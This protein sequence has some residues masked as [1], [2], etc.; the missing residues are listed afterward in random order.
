MHVFLLK[1]SVQLGNSRYSSWIRPKNWTVRVLKA[2]IQDRRGQG[3]SHA[4]DM[5]VEES[6]GMVKETLGHSAITIGELNMILTH[7]CCRTKEYRRLGTKVGECESIFGSHGKPATPT[8]AAAALGPGTGLPYPTP[9]LRGRTGE[10]CSFKR[11]TT[12]PLLLF[13]LFVLFFFQL[14]SV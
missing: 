14:P 10:R 1:M 2:W 4:S 5:C 13:F 12:L 11:R 7:P 6:G 9:T 8:A 3:G